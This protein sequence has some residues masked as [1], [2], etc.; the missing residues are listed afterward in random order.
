ML[1][2]SYVGVTM[3]DPAGI[4][5]E[6]ICRSLHEETLY[7]SCAPVVIGSREA[8]KKAID[9]LKL[10]MR[11][12]EINDPK[13]GIYNSSTINLVH[14]ELGYTF[15]PGVLTADNG[16][17]AIDYMRKAYELLSAG[18]IA[19][20]ASA[21]CHKGAMK[22]AGSPYTGATELFAH[23]A[24]D[25]KTYTVVRQGSCY[26]FQLTAHL[27]LV[28]A[29]QKLTPE[30][31][32]DFIVTAASTLKAWGFHAPKIALSGLNPH[33]GDNGALGNE[34]SDI[35]IPAIQMAAEKVGPVDGPIPADSIFIKG[36]NGTYDAVIALFHDTANIAIKLMDEQY[37]S[38]VITAGLPFIRTTVAHGTAYDIAYKGIAGHAKMLNCIIA[39]ADISNQLQAQ[40]E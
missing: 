23:F 26:I 24:G 17:V 19:A 37:P 7:D 25:L 10:D 38:V 4:G 35:L 14:M 20:I 12:R 39:A 31:V 34:E 18:K 9:V 1:N 21:P 5:P 32:S 22:M 11:I 29:I 13:D 36:Y 6:I 2:K 33:A 15:H 40:K 27:P 16:R 3:G 28:D 8:I 30:F